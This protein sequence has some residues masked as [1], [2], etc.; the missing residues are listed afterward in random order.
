MTEQY[1][2]DLDEAQFAKMLFDHVREMSKDVA[3]VTR[4]GYGPL[5]TQVLEYLKG[6]GGK[7]DLDI[8][9]DLAGN[10]WMTLPGTDR[11]LPAFVSGSHADSVPQGGNYDG[12]AGIVAALCAAHWMRRHHYTPKRDFTVLMMRCEESSFFGKAY[13][14]SLGMMGKL[15]AADLALKHRST[16]ETLGECIRSCGVDPE[17]LTTGEPVIDPK[18]IAAF[19]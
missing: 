3:G 6:I 5:E 13:V 18:R 11:T 17:R 15:T 7:L 16:G 14:G 9:T 12:L 8:Q 10:V 1:S 19:V 4:Q 2:L